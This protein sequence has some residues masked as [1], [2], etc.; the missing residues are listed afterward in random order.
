MNYLKRK[1]NFIGHFRMSYL[2]T[3]F[4]EQTFLLQP[5]N[6]WTLMDTISSC[7]TRTGNMF[8]FGGTIGWSKYPQFFDG[9]RYKIL[10]RPVVKSKKNNMGYSLMRSHWFVNLSLLVEK[11]VLRFVRDKI[12]N[13]VQ[14]CVD[15]QEGIEFCKNVVPSDLRIC[16]TIFTSVSAI[17][18]ITKNVSYVHAHMD[19]NDLI[20]CTLYLGNNVTGGSL[21]FFDGCNEKIIND[22]VHCKDFVHGRIITGEFSKILHGA[23][24]WEGNR[25]VFVFYICKKILKHF[26][27]YGDMY[28][29]RYQKLGYPKKYIN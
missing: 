15:I 22:C 20:S 13:N 7:G 6:I 27:S 11:F 3:S 17:A 5:V 10:P 28:Y 4:I 18:S 14:K 25:V 2:E 21:H 8:L 9:Q 23:M 1:D 26:K 16:D 29:S 24:D 19:K 12:K